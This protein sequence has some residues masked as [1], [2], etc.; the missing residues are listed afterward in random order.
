V[1]SAAVLVVGILAPSIL[2]VNASVIA[3]DVTGLPS[4]ASIFGVANPNVI[5]QT[6][7]QLSAAAMVAWEQQQFPGFTYTGTAGTYLGI[8]D[9]LYTSAQYSTT[10]LQN[11]QTF[12]FPMGFIWDANIYLWT[13]PNAFT[14]VNG[15]SVPYT[16]VYD[17]TTFLQGGQCYVN[18]T[19]AQTSSTCL[20]AGCSTSTTS[21]SST[22]SISSS[23]ST[24]TTTIGTSYSISTPSGSYTTCSG[25]GNGCPTPPPSV[26]GQSNQF[27]V[28]GLVFVGLIGLPVGGLV[29]WKEEKKE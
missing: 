22:G 23:T 15:K 5:I 24:T 7:T 13:N 25:T 2:P 10:T 14:I 9:I 21:Q 1:L 8:P 4:C 12:A 16:F 11:G 6:G 29:T 28:S 17:L 19:T 3:G 20:G 26:I 18:P 27:V